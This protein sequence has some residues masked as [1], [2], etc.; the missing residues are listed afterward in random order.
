[1][2]WL[3]YVPVSANKARGLEVGHEVPVILAEEEDFGA[4]DLISEGLLTFLIPLYDRFLPLHVFL[5]HVLVPARHIT[6]IHL[7]DTEV[8]IL[9]DESLLVLLLFE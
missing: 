8:I 6:V 3:G 9:Y 5:Y 2:V 1:M 7:T 4:F